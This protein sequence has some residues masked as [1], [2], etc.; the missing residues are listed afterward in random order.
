MPRWTIDSERSTLLVRARATLH[1]SVSRGHGL[2]GTLMAEL[3]DLEATASGTIRAALSEQSFG[4][5]VRDWSMARHLNLK[6]HPEARLDVSQ[7]FV[8]SR[9]PWEIRLQGQMSYRGHTAL[10]DVDVRGEL[11]EHS[12]TART[13]FPLELSQIGIAPPRMLFLKVAD[14]VEV[15]VHLVATAD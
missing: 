13:T 9:D 7:V 2:S 10:I 3:E 14:T 4:D 12:L 1:D 11:D 6:R 5:R 8:K 15:E